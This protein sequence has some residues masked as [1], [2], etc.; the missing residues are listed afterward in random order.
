MV[1]LVVRNALQWHH[2]ALLNTTEASPGQGRNAARGALRVVVYAGVDPVSKKRV[3]LTE[4]IPAGTSNAAKLA[5]RARTKL[6]GQVDE[7]RAPKTSA[8]V[9]QLLDHHFE[10]LDVESTTLDSYDSLARLHIRPLLGD[11]PLGRIGGEIL[12]SFYKELRTCRAHCRGRRFIEHRTDSDHACDERRGPHICRPLADGTVRK[13][14]AILSGAGKRAVRWGWV[15]VNPFDI[16]EP[17]PTSKPDP[18]PPSP[19]QAAAI[20]NGPSATSTWA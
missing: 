10:M 13:I 6:L 7:R 16:A 1:L 12:D 14:D 3:Y 17:T 20:V 19:E 18:R 8:T 11:Q 2:V 9:N 15:G 5:E 4:V